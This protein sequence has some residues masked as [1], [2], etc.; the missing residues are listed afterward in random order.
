LLKLENQYEVMKEKEEKL[1]PERINLGYSLHLAYSEKVEKLQTAIHYSEEEITNLKLEQSNLQKKE[2]ESQS[3]HLSYQEAYGSKKSKIEQYQEIEGHFNQQYPFK[4]ERNI[5]GTYED[6]TFEV[7]Q[8]QQE[9]EHKQVQHELLT[10]S[11]NRQKREEERERIQRNIQDCSLML[12]QLKEERKIQQEK[13]E[14]YEKEL[15]TR[16][17]YMKYLAIPEEKKFDREFLCLKFNEKINALQ[18]SM[19]KVER[20]EE[21][22]EKELDK[23]R[24]GVIL[25]LPKNFETLLHSLDIHF[26][27][28]MDYLK[29]N[30]YNQE[31]NKELLEKVPL[32]PFSIMMS[33]RELNKLEKAAVNFYTS[34]PIPIVVKEQMNHYPIRDS[35]VIYKE[36][37]LNLFIAFNRQLLDEKELSR[38]LH[39]KEEQ[40][41]ELKERLL[42]KKEEIQFYAS[43]GQ[44]ITYQELNLENYQRLQTE[45]EK[46]QKQEEEEEKRLLQLRSDKANNDERI[47]QMQKQCQDLEKTKQK[48]EQMQ[49]AIENMKNRYEQY[50]EDCQELSRLKKGMEQLF[51]ESRDRQKRIDDIYQLISD[52][53][54]YSSNLDRELKTASDKN[55]KYS[56]YKKGNKI[57]KE[58]VDIETRYLA[59]TEKMNHDVKLI[60]DQLEQSRNRFAKVQDRL[61][62]LSRKY[63]IEDNQ[64]KE[65]SYSQLREKELEQQ[66][67]D[68]KSQIETAEKKWNTLDKEIA[69]KESK[70][71]DRKTEMKEDYH[72]EEPIPKEQIV[73][74][75]FKARE[76]LIKLSVQEE[77]KKQKVFVSRRIGYEANMSALSEFSNLGYE[78][79]YDFAQE[80]EKYQKSGLEELDRKEVEELYGSMIREF[81]SLQEQARKQKLVLEK[82][83]ESLL[84]NE[85][86]QEDFYHQPLTLM[87][88]IA[89]KPEDLLK[90]LTITLQSY[91]ILL[92]KLEIDIAFID[93]EKE[94]VVEM[95]F[96]YVMEIH[97]NLDKIDRNSTITIKER[98]IRM[99]RIQVPSWEEN[100]EIYLQRMTGFFNELVNTG[101]QCITENQNLEEMIGVRVTSKTLYDQVIGIGTTNIKL[102]KIEAQREY[103][104]TW[105]QVSKNSGGEGFLSA[106]VVLTSL[107]SYMRRDESDLFIEREEGKVLVMD[108]PFAQTNASHLLI[109]LMDIAKKCNTQLICLTGLGGESIYNRFDN[110]YVLNLIESGLQ[111]DIQYLKADHVKGDTKIYQLSTARVQVEEAEQMELLF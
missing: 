24:H 99:L 71:A 25:D 38:L 97:K 110:I 86:Y 62:E 41:K 74:T 2:K 106:F 61:I 36:K 37:Q 92:E 69:I 81:R 88:Q 77:E 43:M 107:L 103:P 1:I 33:E 5:L 20:E 8:R 95:L 54:L 68:L 67:A 27:T 19:K 17:R 14:K 84:G 42:K 75:S 66:L 23:M 28:G 70:I 45:M 18:E 57:D 102:Y 55:N 83:V 10:T 47:E 53:K 51:I 16:L 4:L 73:D 90:Q 44:E 50:L 49:S 31:Q 46:S 35:S 65:F 7:I 101:L 72:K 79:E 6:G 9:Q 78:K 48:L 94:K 13:E 93:R 60:E 11:S 98:S 82:T 32:L 104:I 21:K 91:S 85:R 12:G 30:G 22:L 108:N 64:Y 56:S 87:K 76:K 52:K 59:I 3:S 89:D 34:Y 29:H 58:L 109:P 100:K 96:D 105:A 111:R 39:E 26:V 15:E 63:G 80:M 40:L